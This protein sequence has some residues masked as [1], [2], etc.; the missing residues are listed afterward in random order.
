MHPGAS[1]ALVL[2]SS[3]QIRSGNNYIMVDNETSN[4]IFPNKLHF[5]QNKIQTETDSIF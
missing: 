1:A 3:I 4:W 2:T 5:L